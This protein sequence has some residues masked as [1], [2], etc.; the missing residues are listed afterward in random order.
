[1]NMEAINLDNLIKKYKGLWVALTDSYKVISADKTAKKVHEEAKK[2]GY[3]EPILF[4]V[5][6]KNLP[7]VG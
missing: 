7:F 5:P 6:Q 4:K 2:Q 3:K 1:M